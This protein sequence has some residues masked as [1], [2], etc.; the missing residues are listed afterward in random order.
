ME[1]E[2]LFEIAVHL[3]ELGYNVGEI[4]KFSDHGQGH[5][6]DV[7][8]VAVFFP[9]GPVLIDFWQGELNVY[10]TWNDFGDRE[11]VEHI[12]DLADPNF[13]GEIVKALP[14]TPVGT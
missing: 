9:G 6:G 5:E 3:A 7:W 14:K 8:S 2:I 1:Q 10:R 13:L 12:I 4:D 11:S